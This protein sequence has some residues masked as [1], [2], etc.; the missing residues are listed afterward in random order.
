MPREGG[1]FHVTQRC[2]NQSFLL[3]FARDR[4]AYRAKLREH[5]PKF[6]LALLDYCL[7]SNHVHLLMDAAD[8]REISG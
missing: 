5:L 8:R 3:K 1:I 6:D 4:Q 2:H 7:T